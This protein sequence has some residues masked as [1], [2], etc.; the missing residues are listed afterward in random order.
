MSDHSPFAAL[1]HRLGNPL[2]VT[3]PAGASDVF[4]LVVVARRLPSEDRAQ[5]LRMARLMLAD[6][7]STAPEQAEARA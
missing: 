7:S 5:L 4:E 3:R 2:A 1:A 6:A